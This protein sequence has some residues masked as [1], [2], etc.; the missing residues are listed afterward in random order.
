MTTRAVI[1]PHAGLVYSG[2]LAYRGIY[3]LD[4]KLKTLFIIAPAHK[5]YFNGIAMMTYD[6]CKTPLGDIE[7][8]KE[9]CLRLEQ[10]GL[11]RFDD[12]VWE[13]EHS[14]EIQLPIIQSI[15]EDVKIVPLL[16]SEVN[17]EVI[18]NIIEKFYFNLQNGFIISSDLSHFLQNDVARK[19]DNDTAIALENL[20]YK[21][22]DSSS[23]CGFKGIQGLLMFANQNGYSLIRLGMTNSSH[24]TKDPSSVV[25]YGAWALWEDSVNHFIKDH[26]SD[27]IISLSRNVILNGFEKK[28]IELRYRQVL[29]Q[30]GACFVTL[31]KNGALRGC[32]GSI[33]AHKPLIADIIDNSR[34]AAFSDARF[35][36][37]EKEEL[38]DIKVAISLLS[39]PEEINFKT[40]Q[41]LLDK[42]VP[43]EDG[44]I[45]KDK[46]YQAVYLP[47][48]WDELS[49]KK[50]F[51]NSLKIKA[52]LSPEHFSETFKAYK[53]S[54]EYIEE[55]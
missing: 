19:K 17:S 47:S 4:K 21:K 30:N 49:D 29:N 23:A 5:A 18:A 24:L 12:N 39:A 53:F 15:F 2:A 28:R 26:C 46:E 52:G 13:N 44:I 32:I 43:F 27:F 22:L 37:V 16:V 45:I 48:V 33:I 54:V 20:E 40:E 8:D 36:P 41:E 51:L 34:N 55:K 11:A 25:G 9:I 7:I 10:E 6:A 35:S 50:E 3:N 1:V 14:V 42:I 38:K 31:H